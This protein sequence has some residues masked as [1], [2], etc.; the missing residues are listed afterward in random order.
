[1]SIDGEHVG[2][3]FCIVHILP[4]QPNHFNNVGESELVVL[5]YW[6][7]FGLQLCDKEKNVASQTQVEKHCRAGMRASEVCPH[8]PLWLVNTFLYTKIQH[9]FRKQ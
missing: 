2:H 9:T 1:M 5:F 7:K 6:H 4:T 3:L 8:V